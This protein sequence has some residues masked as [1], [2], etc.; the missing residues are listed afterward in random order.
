[1]LYDEGRREYGDFTSTLA[2]EYCAKFGYTLFRHRELLDKSLAP[3]WNK[4]LA[5]QQHINDFD[6]VLWLDADAMILQQDTT[7]ES[8]IAEHSNAKDIIFSVDGSGLC[9]GIFLIKNTPWAKDFLKTILFLG[10][11][12]DCSFLYEQKTIHS[13]YN[14][15]P[16][17]KERVG[18]IPE[19]LIQNHKSVFSPTAFIMHFWGY[20][21]PFNVVDKIILNIVKKGWSRECFPK[22]YFRD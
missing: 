2:R 16:S 5:V 13:L 18:I 11:E 3:S 14:L 10:E 22:H 21:F 17:I 8:I 9:A 7:L 19:A 20:H 6:W 15:Y 4:L 12:P 1:M